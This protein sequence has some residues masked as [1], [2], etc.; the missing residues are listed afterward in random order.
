MQGMPVNDGHDLDRVE[1]FTFK[2]KKKMQKQPLYKSLYAQV[3]C[4]IIIG[5][6]LGHFVPETGTAMKPLGTVSSN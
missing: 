2:E 3:I 1:C 4:A 5:I 6:L